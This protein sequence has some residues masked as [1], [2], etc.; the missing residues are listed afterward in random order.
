MKS[1][2]VAYKHGSRYGKV[3]VEAHTKQQAE[4]IARIQVQGTYGKSKFIALK[5]LGQG[6]RDPDDELAEMFL[7][8][9]A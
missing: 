7:I 1:Y 3:W 2:T 8:K 5:V 9:K 4:E 6:E